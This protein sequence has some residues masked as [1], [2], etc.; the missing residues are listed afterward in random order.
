MA[1]STG[2][3][4]GSSRSPPFPRR[5][6]RSKNPQN[7]EI[8]AETIAASATV[9]EATTGV[10]AV[11]IGARM[12]AMRGAINAAIAAISALK[13]RRVNHRRRVISNPGVVNKVAEAASAVT[14]IVT[15]A[16]ASAKDSRHASLASR[17]QRSR[18]ANR[19]RRENR[20]NHVRTRR[21]RIRPLPQSRRLQAR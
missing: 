6:R 14:V 12:G 8:R 11:T 1:G 21:E 17:V 5:W 3:L 4:R 18:R 16:V 19:V 2:C 15:A 7:G 10:M 20:A 9:R 13:A